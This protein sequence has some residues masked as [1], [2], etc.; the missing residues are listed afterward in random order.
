MREHRFDELSKLISARSSRRGLLKGALGLAAGG[1]LSRFGREDT[2]TAEERA[3]SVAPANEAFQRTWARTDQPVASGAANRTWMW[4]PE[5]F[6][7]A[8]TEDYTESPGGQR[9]VQYFDKSRMELTYPELDPANPFFVTNGRLAWELITGQM[10]VGNDD[11]ITRQPAQ[12][13]IAGD[14][15]ERP[16][17]AEI[18]QLGM[19][20]APATVPG[21]TI[22][23]TY[24]DG[25]IG[26]DDS[27][28]Q[29]GVTAAEQITVP[30]IDH[31]V[32]SVFWE[33]TNQ[34]GPV[35]IDGETTEA[36]LFDPWFFATGLPITEAYW[37]RVSIGGTAQDVLWQC[38][39]RRC[40]TYTPTNA[41][42]WQVEAGNVGQHYFAW[43][44]TPQ[45]DAAITKAPPAVEAQLA[46]TAGGNS[47]YQQL[48]AYL[49]AQGFS[50]LGQSATQASGTGLTPTSFLQVAYESSPPNPL[51]AT[52]TFDPD[53]SGVA[54]TYATVVTALD[55]L[56]YVLYVD[57]NGQ[58][59]A[60]FPTSG[61]STTTTSGSQLQGSDPCARCV[62]E[63]LASPY[64]YFE[65]FLEA[66]GSCTELAHVFCESTSPDAGGSA[67]DGN[68][69]PDV[70]V[71]VDLITSV[72]LKQ[73]T[74]ADC[75][76]RCRPVC[77]DCT[78]CS[79]TDTSNFCCQGGCTNLNTDANNCGSCGAR[80]APGQ[81]CCGGTC[82]DILSDN[83]NCGACGAACPDGHDC[84]NGVCYAPADPCEAC[85]GNDLSNY[86]CDGVCLDLLNDVQNCGGCG[87]DCFAGQICCDGVCLDPLDDDQNC[88]GC[89]V[90]CNDNENCV[91]GVCQQPG[92]CDACQAD[93]VCCEDMCVDILS[94]DDHCGACGIEC[95][96]GTDCID[97]LC[98]ECVSDGDCGACEVCNDD[99][100]CRQCSGTCCANGTCVPDGV[101]CPELIDC[102]G[103]LC[104]GG[105]YPHCCNDYDYCCSSGFPVCCGDSSC[106]PSI[107]PVCCPDDWCC[108]PGCTC[109]GN[110]GC[111]CPE[112]LELD[113]AIS[114]GAA[115][116]FG[117]ASGAETSITYW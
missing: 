18:E 109:T 94:N 100:R 97:G 4:G 27:Y 66:T 82:I 102:G 31:T 112:D 35:Y 41:P 46:E 2:T 75:E 36:Q 42:G 33:F 117:T 99:G 57:V 12:V 29:F 3:P 62:N 44:T 32:A 5:A 78:T 43:R 107:Y 80:C 69:A 83:A 86:C 108:P 92:P 14:P 106:C 113:I 15:G 19:L 7:E 68:Q 9:T 88:G 37:S 59:Q 24:A 48:A 38:F 85:P 74:V 1:L 55:D 39:E 56:L 70:V 95:P 20:T 93:E 115:G 72:C 76:D 101:C 54:T 45:E 104:C 77:P 26:A 50:Q 58:V 116:A 103:G 114:V 13:N 10:Q 30:G 21:T 11:F 52:L 63:C 84:V 65:A 8:L 105:D 111:H 81:T 49:S 79:G 90:V 23:T 28:A 47:D 110:Q 89:G 40:L 60:H 16:T 34:S 6:T 64:A 51:Q 71:C 91:N 98:L 87:L 25:A 73:A 61:G 17:Y 67:T 53:L 22:T 96:A